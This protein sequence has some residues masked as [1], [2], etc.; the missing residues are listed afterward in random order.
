MRDP[1]SQPDTR[2]AAGFILPLLAEPPPE[3]MDFPA[4]TQGAD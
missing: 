2:H 1:S 4:V 3:S